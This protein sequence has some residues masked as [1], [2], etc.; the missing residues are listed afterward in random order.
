M[1]SDNLDWLPCEKKIARAAYD[2]AVA[3]ALARVMAELKRRAETARAPSDM[4][5][6]EAYLREARRDIDAIFIYSYPKLPGVFA[7][8]I[9][10]GYLDEGRLSGLA[11][12]KLSAIRRFL[13]FAR[14]NP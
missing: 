1:S 9:H 4:S 5:A 11:E 10:K 12:D 2:A 7:Y 6:I 13:S 3:A 14:T 8:A